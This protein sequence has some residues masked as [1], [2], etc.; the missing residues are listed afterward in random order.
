MDELELPDFTQFHCGT[1]ELTPG[2]LSTQLLSSISRKDI[3]A[4]DDDDRHDRCIIITKAEDRSCKS[5]SHSSF[6]RIDA[7]NMIYY[8]ILLL[9]YLKE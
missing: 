3:L 7:H 1:T 8:Y 4:F 2:K 9:K 5:A 6:I